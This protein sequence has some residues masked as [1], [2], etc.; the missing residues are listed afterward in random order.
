[1]P[2]SSSAKNVYIST[3][4]CA[5]GA[6]RALWLHCNSLY[7]EK[8]ICLSIPVCMIVLT[9]QHT[10]TF[11]LEPATCFPLSL[12]SL[13]KNYAVLYS[14]SEARCCVRP[15]GHQHD[16]SPCSACDW[17]RGSCD[18]SRDTHVRAS[19]FVRLVICTRPPIVNEA[20]RSAAWADRFSTTH[21][22]RVAL[23]PL[24]SHVPA[25]EHRCTGTSRSRKA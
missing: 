19:G 18:P 9:C 16:R 3:R 14:R 2:P 5:I 4:L 13:S 22:T 8:R 15:P 24:R 21:L 25:H 20:R 12:L 23:V 17:V 1:M 6:V 11:F 7:D 10:P